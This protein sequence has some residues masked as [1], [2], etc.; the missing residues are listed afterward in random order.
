MTT[1][2]R[3]DFLIRS[4]LAGG[5]ALSGPAF[6]AACGSSGKKAAPTTTV[7]GDKT[8]TTQAPAPGGADTVRMANWVLY[9]G[10]DEQPSNTPTLKSFTDST[11]LKVVYRTA[12]D[13]ND[14]FT[15]VNKGNL[16][17]KADIGYDIAVVT[18]WMAARWIAKGWVHDLPEAMIP[19]RTNV[20]DRLASPSWDPGRK[21]SL[22]YAIGQVGIAYYPDKVGFEITSVKQ[23]LDAKLKGRVSLLSEMRDTTGLFMLADG[24]DPSKADVAGTKAAIATIKKARDGGQFRA[25][26]GNSYVEDLDLGDVWAA[27]AWSGDIATLQANRPELKWVLPSD[28]AMSFTD[29]MVIPAGAKNVDGAGRLMNHFYDPA[30]SGPLFETIQY[31]SPVKGAGEKMSAKASG[32]V[33]INPPAG[34]KIVEF[35]DL[36]E[37]QADELSTAYDE[38][39]KL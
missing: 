33:L 30:I 32:N 39:T 18:S 21:K 25:I 4:G 35:A 12:V 15:E 14:E 3:R 29:T 22:P 20:L 7:A 38:A 26:K 11:K 27:V 9:I 5:A 8:A 28:G 2:N 1:F 6:L 19:N 37:E 23:L 24:L 13:G 36:T 31:V 10:D 16:E 17:K 34:A